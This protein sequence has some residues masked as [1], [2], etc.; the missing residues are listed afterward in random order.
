MQYNNFTWNF[1]NPSIFSFVHNYFVASSSS[2]EPLEYINFL[3][4]YELK[5]LLCIISAAFLL[6][7]EH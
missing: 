5:C 4:M 2:F 7:F 1:C 3:V 6:R